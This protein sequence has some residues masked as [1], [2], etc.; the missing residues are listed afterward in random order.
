MHI[1]YIYYIF[2]YIVLYLN[3]IKLYKMLKYLTLVI[4]LCVCV[5][6]CLC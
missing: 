2:R 5:C 3:L 6:V 4:S 1:L